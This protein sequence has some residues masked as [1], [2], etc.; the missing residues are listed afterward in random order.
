MAQ[1]QQG[2][3]FIELLLTSIFVTGLVIAN[4]TASKVIYAFGLTWPAGT[5]AYA[6]TFLMTDILGDVFGKD[7]AERVVIIGFI[8]NVIMAVLVWAAV[9]APIAP[10]QKGY[11]AI[12]ARVLG[13]AP[14]IVAAS[15]IAYLISQTHDVYAFHFWKRLTR[16][17]YLLLRNN[18]S[19]IVS[20]FIDTCTFTFF[21][22]YA[23]PILIWGQPWIELSDLWNVVIGQYVIKV[24]IALCDTPFCYLGVYLVRKSLERRGIIMSRI[25]RG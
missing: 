11:Q 9:N 14:N 2:A 20:Q 5:L 12:Y 13:Q 8:C 19:T 10:F 7:Y 17:R 23:L 21:A 24:I 18:A 22:F 4:L 3:T 1:R 25:S 15:M 16:G 6:I